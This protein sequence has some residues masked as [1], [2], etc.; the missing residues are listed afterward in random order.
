MSNEV[1]SAKNKLQSLLSLKSERELALMKLKCEI[2]EQKNLIIKLV[3]E[4]ERYDSI[5][6]Q[7]NKQDILLED[8]P[9]LKPKKRNRI[10]IITTKSS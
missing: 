8:S 7:A 10:K 4:Q 5:Y 3:T 9:E 1:T 2:K 6:N